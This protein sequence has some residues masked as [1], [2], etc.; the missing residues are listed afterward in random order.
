[1][2]VVAPLQENTINIILW[3]QQQQ[4]TT[5]TAD[6][7]IQETR[8]HGIED[9]ENFL[10]LALRNGNFLIRQIRRRRRRRCAGKKI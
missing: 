3:R 1:M 8:I 4:L 9:K 2:T 7:N 6:N 10:T 5:T